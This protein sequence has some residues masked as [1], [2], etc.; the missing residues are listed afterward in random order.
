MTMASEMADMAC[1]SDEDL[2]LLVLSDP[3]TS[4]EE[5]EEL[6]QLETSISASDIR[7]W[8]LP[9]ILS[10]SIIKVEANRSRQITYFS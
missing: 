4:Q 10:S 2:V 8:N 9:L 5:E 7:N 3:S 6:M 1:A